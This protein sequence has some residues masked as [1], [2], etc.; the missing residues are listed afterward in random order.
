MRDYDPNH[1]LRLSG[2]KELNPAQLEVFEEW[3]NSF[4]DIALRDAATDDV[5]FWAFFFSSRLESIKRN[6]LERDEVSG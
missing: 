3:W 1:A 5:L 2:H 4:V 6:C